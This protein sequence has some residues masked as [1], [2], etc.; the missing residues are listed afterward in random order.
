VWT[1]T[2]PRIKSE[3]MLRSKTLWVLFLAGHA[4]FWGSIV[5]AAADG[6]RLRAIDAFRRSGIIQ[7]NGRKTA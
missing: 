1:G 4:L 6:K 3:D 5:N 7:P 2:H